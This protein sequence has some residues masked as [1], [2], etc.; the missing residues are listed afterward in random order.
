[1]RVRQDD[2]AGWIAVRY[3]KGGAVLEGL[4]NLSAETAVVPVGDASRWQLVFSSEAPGYGGAG[5]AALAQELTLPGRA[6]VL[7]RRTGA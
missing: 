6:A 4:F 3:E 1:V 7:L 2:A 5:Q